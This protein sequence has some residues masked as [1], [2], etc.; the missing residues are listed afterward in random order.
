M[1]TPERG[2]E[3]VRQTEAEF[4][5]AVERATEAAGRESPEMARQALED[6]EAADVRRAEVADRY[7]DAWWDLQAQQDR[8]W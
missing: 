4:S 8:Q 2:A 5:D 3:E 1:S 7:P 6:A